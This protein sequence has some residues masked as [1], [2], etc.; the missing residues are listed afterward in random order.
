MHFWL[1]VIGTNLTFL[2][3]FALGYLGMPRRV[4]TYAVFDGFGLLNLLASI[5]AAFLVAGMTVFAVNVLR[6]LRRRSLGRA[7]PAGDDPWEAHTLEWTTAS[8]PPPLNFPAGRPLVPVSSFAPLLDLR[9]R[10]R[11]GT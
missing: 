2:P 1:L 10:E 3:M 7:E 6:T 9:R 8:P 11:S 5:G 4:A